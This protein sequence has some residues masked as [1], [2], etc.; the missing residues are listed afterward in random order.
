MRRSNGGH[1]LPP[2]VGVK[3]EGMKLRP[4]KDR[5]RPKRLMAGALLFR[6]ITGEKV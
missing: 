5:K 2:P 1:I 6:S 4:K 3:R